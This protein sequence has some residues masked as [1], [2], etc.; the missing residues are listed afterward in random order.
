M[1][2]MK[3]ITAGLFLLYLMTSSFFG[4]GCEPYHHHN[5]ARVNK[6]DPD[7]HHNHQGGDPDAKQDPTDGGH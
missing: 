1:G 2:S 4:M 3:F 6:D 5:D 7:N